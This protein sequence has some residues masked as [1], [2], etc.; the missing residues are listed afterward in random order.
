MNGRQ[1]P[2][3][4]PDR[5]RVEGQPRLRVVGDERLVCGAEQRQTL[6]HSQLLTRGWIRSGNSGHEIDQSVTHTHCRV[7]RVV[8]EVALRYRHAAGLQVGV[9]QS[10]VP[11]GF[12]V[13]DGAEHQRLGHRPGERT[14]FAPLTLRQGNIEVWLEVGAAVHPGRIA[15]DPDDV[16]IQLAERGP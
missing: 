5:V 3:K 7:D 4:L 2:A 12:D 15:S 10:A 13:R 14:C 8:S 1:S 11:H 16:E 9:E 6:C